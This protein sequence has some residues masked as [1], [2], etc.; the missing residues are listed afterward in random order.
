MVKQLKLPL[1]EAKEI[2]KNNTQTGIASDDITVEG[3]PVKIME[4]KTY[5]D[6][7]NYSGWTFLSGDETQTEL[8]NITYSG[9]YP[10]NYI[11]NCDNKIIKFLGAPNGRKITF[12]EEDHPTVEHL[13]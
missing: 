9:E 1:E 2:L 8:D 5:K 13:T 12:N 10:L 6:H 7:P 11:A 3:K 4:R